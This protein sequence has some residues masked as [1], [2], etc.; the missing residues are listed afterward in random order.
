MFRGTSF[1]TID[2]KGRIIIPARF[3]DVIKAGGGNGVMVTQLDGCL[4]AYPFSEWRVI[5]DR[6]RS[7]VKRNDS[8]RRFRRLF[9]GGAYEC[10]CDKQDRILVPP[11]HRDYAE[12]NKHIV[13]I[14]VL[15]HFEIWSKERWQ[16]E[17]L[18]LAE[19]LKRDDVKDDIAIL[20]L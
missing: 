10:T 13:L 11:I 16:Q 1:H 9:V 14:G 2:T 19:D 7:M 5:E 15:D 17:S 3:R 18:Q 12:L 6:I 20:G 4:K 8:L